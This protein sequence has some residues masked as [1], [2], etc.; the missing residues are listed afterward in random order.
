MLAPSDTISKI[1]PVEICA[2]LPRRMAALGLD[3]DTVAR[4]DPDIFGNLRRLCATCEYHERCRGDLRQDYANPAWQAYCPN[5]ATL[6]ALGVLPWLG[7][8]VVC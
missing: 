1:T 4:F 2:L 3:A 5:S 8:L 7:G 6:R